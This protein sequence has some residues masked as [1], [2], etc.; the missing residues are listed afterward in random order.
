MANCQLLNPHVIQP[1]TSFTPAPHFASSVFY[2]RNREASTVCFKKNLMVSLHCIKHSGRPRY[3]TVCV[4]PVSLYPRNF[5]FLW[6]CF[7][8]LVHWGYSF[9]LPV[10][11]TARCY[12]CW[13]QILVGLIGLVCWLQYVL[14]CVNLS[15]FTQFCAAASHGSYVPYRSCP[16]WIQCVH[17][18]FESHTSVFINIPFLLAMILLLKVEFVKTTNK[19]TYLK[20]TKIRW[21]YTRKFE[22][23]SNTDLIKL[24]MVKHMD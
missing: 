9:P 1:K 5:V 11:W 12:P 4:Q 6:E 15:Y 23:S 7:V 19:K 18:F 2:T 13:R 17:G 14:A 16:I 22:F 21:R 8:V 24:D 10:A 20:I 3:C